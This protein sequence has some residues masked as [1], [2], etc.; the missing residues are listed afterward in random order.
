[1]R[2]FTFQ[3]KT[4]ELRGEWEPKSVRLG[5]REAAHELHAAPRNCQTIPRRFALQASVAT[6]LVWSRH[7]IKWFP[8]TAFSD[9]KTLRRKR[10]HRQVLG[11]RLP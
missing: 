3:K 1:V 11:Y 10:I 5:D 6:M 8:T 4:T 2:L 9:E 7:R